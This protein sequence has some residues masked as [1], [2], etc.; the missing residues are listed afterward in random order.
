[1]EPLK[2]AVVTG[3]SRGIGLAV[4]DRF[5]Q[6]EDWR[7]VS[8]DIRPVGRQRERVR[9]VCADVANPEAVGEA[10]ESVAAMEGEITALVNNAGVQRVALSHVMTVES[11]QE[12]ISTNLTGPFLC[13]RQ[14]VPLLRSPGA[15]I[16]NVSSVASQLGLSGRGPYCSAKAGLLGLTRVMA[17]ELAKRGVRVN[18]V[19]PGFTR[20]E[21]IAQGIQNGSLQEE[22]MTRQVPMARLAEPSEV[23]AVVYFLCSTE[24]SFITGQCVVVDG[25][26]SVQGLPEVPDWLDTETLNGMAAGSC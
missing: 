17:V 3:G 7:V 9:A 16:V 6:E 11:W 13:S 8:I 18:A 19:A 22:W 21:L 23:A 14:A 4:I 24:A 20:T 25:G 12:V 26:W 15:A 2:V 1:M 10:F 5:L